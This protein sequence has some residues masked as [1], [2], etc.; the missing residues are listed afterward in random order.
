MSVGP[1]SIK[2]YVASRS[3]LRGRSLRWGG[4]MRM[5][6]LSRRRGK[7]WT[8][9]DRWGDEPN[10]IRRRWGGRRNEK[11]RVPRSRKNECVRIVQMRK[12]EKM[13]TQ[14]RMATAE[15]YSLGFA[16]LEVNLRVGRFE[17]KMYSSR[18]PWRK[19]A[20]AAAAQ[21][22]LQCLALLIITQR[23]QIGK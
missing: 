10:S 16:T 2:W 1:S 18:T 8:R 5:V 9:K 17:S 12:S 13:S 7:R 21:T 22:G 19:I 6:C 4:M 20:V 14:V 3:S 15:S 11:N 23:S